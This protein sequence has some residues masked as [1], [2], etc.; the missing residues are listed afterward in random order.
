MKSTQ[1][2]PSTHVRIYIELLVYNY[3]ASPRHQRVEYTCVSEERAKSKADRLK[4]LIGHWGDSS[5]RTDRWLTEHM[6]I[7]GF[8]EQ[9]EGI[10]RQITTRIE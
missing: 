3:D 8:I 4:K 2:T 9:V 10:F 6:G 1:F 7:Y 5:N